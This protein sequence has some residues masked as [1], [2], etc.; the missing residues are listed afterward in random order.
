MNTFFPEIK[1]NFGFG[2]MR[3]PKDGE[4]VDISAVQA[5]VD[6]FL[7]AGF[8]YFDTA[9]PYHGG[10]S[11]TIL[12]QVLTSRYPRES[13]ILTN[14]LSPTFFETEEATSVHSVQFSQFCWHAAPFSAK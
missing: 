6:A 12:R 1:K 14:K 2:C 9:R 7:A 4:T 10:Q 5:M 3:F 13:Y 11:E 8:N